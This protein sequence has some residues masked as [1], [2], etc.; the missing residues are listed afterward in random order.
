M[1]GCGGQQIV[2][3]VSFEGF[4][5]KSGS[6][7]MQVARNPQKYPS[8][9]TPPFIRPYQGGRLVRRKTEPTGPGDPGGYFFLNRHLWCI[10]FA[11]R[12]LIVKFPEFLLNLFAFFLKNTI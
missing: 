9:K 11:N 1:R 7:G 3:I 5:V 12:H 8:K 6:V 4:C 2:A 10:L